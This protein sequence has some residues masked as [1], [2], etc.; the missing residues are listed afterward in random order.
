MESYVYSLD[1]QKKLLQLARQS[2]EEEL[3]I[4]KPIIL[5]EIEKNPKFKEFR[6][7]FVT[8]KKKG[9]LRGCIGFPYATNY[10]YK[11]IYEAAKESAVGDPRFVQLTKEEL[12]QINIEIS[13][14]TKPEK[15]TSI[16]DIQ[17]GRDGLI[18]KFMGSSGLLLPQVAKEFNLNKIEF[19]EALCDKAGLPKGTWQQRG[20][21]L[22][23]FQAQIFSE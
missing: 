5:P 19:L 10:L 7:V 11:N 8:L 22:Y 17:I 18:C 4:N 16:K 1:E 14:L 3:H 20:F 13:I 9:H 6:G 12:K 15:I 21:E 23:K 2:I